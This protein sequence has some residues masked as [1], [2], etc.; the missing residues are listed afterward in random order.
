MSEYM[1]QVK[2]GLSHATV[3]CSKLGYSCWQRERERERERDR[4]TERQ[5]ERERERERIIFSQ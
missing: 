5:R 2:I 1:R 4:E 3:V